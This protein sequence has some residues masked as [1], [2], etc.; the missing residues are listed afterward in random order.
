MQL[1]GLAAIVQVMTQG[2]LGAVGGLVCMAVSALVEHQRPS[3]ARHLQRL[4]AQLRVRPAAA[5]PA[6]GACAGFDR[7]GK[8]LHGLQ[9]L[10]LIFWLAPEAYVTSISCRWG[11]YTQRPIDVFGVLRWT[12]WCALAFLAA[13]GIGFSWQEVPP[14]QCGFACL[15]ALQGLPGLG[16]CPVLARLGRTT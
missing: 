15:G 1:A 5:T 4:Q 16:C 7:V 8:H 6:L 9:V 14:W 11:G 12:C 10:N 2:M 13:T 3:P